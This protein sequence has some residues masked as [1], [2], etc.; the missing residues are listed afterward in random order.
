MAGDVFTQGFQN[1]RDLPN[2]LR[3]VGDRER[4]IDNDVRADHR[5]WSR[6]P[7]LFRQLESMHLAPF[8]R[9]GEVFVANVARRGAQGDLWLSFRRPRFIRCI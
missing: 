4:M 3:Q 8:Q 1:M 7:S 6:Q 5:W 2:R 9:L